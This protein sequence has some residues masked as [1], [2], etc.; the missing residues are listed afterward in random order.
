[1][2][3]SLEDLLLKE[4]RVFYLGKLELDLSAK[5]ALNCK[6]C[7][8]PLD[9]VWNRKLKAYLIKS[10]P[11][12]KKKGNKAYL[13]SVFGINTDLS[14]KY[15]EE[16]C[17][18]TYIKMPLRDR[19]I[20]KHGYEKGI[21]KYK[22]FLEGCNVSLEGFIKRNGIKKGIKKYEEFKRKS[23]VTESAMISR[24]GEKE[25]LLKYSQMIDR[26]R[27]KSKFTLSYWVDFFEGDYA[28]AT[29]A[30]KK[31]QTRSI[32][33]FINRYGEENGSERYR[34][35]MDIRKIQN[36]IEYRIKKHGVEKGTEKWKNENILKSKASNI[37]GFTERYGEKIG[38]EKYE[39][40]KR[41]KALT[42]DNF[43]RRFGIENGY[44]KYIE[45]RKNHL[46]GL[47][48][49]VKKSFFQ[50]ELIE[51]VLKY[52]TFENDFL[53]GDT[54]LLLYDENLDSGC[55]YDICN[56]ILKKIVEIHGDYWHANPVLFPPDRIHPVKNKK[57]SEIWEEDKK[58]TELAK[59]FGYDVLVLWEKDIRFNRY[60]E[61]I[62]CIKFLGGIENGLQKN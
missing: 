59:S 43:V 7:N 24:H 49:R 44:L 18:K 30:Y 39:E 16:Y 61:I 57:A 62:K 14:K 9:L 17:K 11:C 10:C 32:D 4:K 51:D 8:N 46:K 27:K 3:M 56:P 45:Y 38:K 12:Q 52:G 42:I 25:G 41:S 54:E 40:S 37:E 29:E 35:L 47:S 20:K 2:I 48:A 50:R 21:E 36:S 15:W 33:W 28:L 31:F 53:Y 26:M 5:D 22:K 55:M 6:I 58:R 19:L 1:M 13:Q 23:L 60:P 34:K